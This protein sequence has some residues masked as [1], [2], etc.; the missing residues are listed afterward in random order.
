MLATAMLAAG[1][2]PGRSDPASGGGSGGATARSMEEHFSGKVQPQL[3][4]CRTCHIPGGVADVEDGHDFMLSASKSQDMANLRASWERLGKNNPTS[5]ILLMSSG[6]ETPHSGGAPW[7]VGSAQYRNMEILLKCFESPASCTA[8]LAGGIDAGELLPLLGSTHAKTLWE[9]YC[10]GKAD[11]VALPTDPRTMIRPGINEGKAVFFNAW[12]EDCHANLPEKEQAPKTCGAYRERRERG[13]EAFIDTLAVGS[14]KAEDYNDSWKKWGLSERPANFDEL[15]TLRYGYNNAPFRNPY[16]LPG[17][18]PNASNGGNGQLP[19]GKR[20]LKDEQGRWTGVIGE[21]ACFGCHG[22][23]IG[24]TGDGGSRIGMKNLG[25]GNNNADTVIQAA[26]GGSAYGVSLGVPLL[27]NPFA[28]GG[29]QRGQNNAVAGFELL[30][31]LL[32]YDSLGLNPNALKLAQNSADPHPTSEQQDTP[33][34]WNYGHRARKFFDAGQSIDSTRIVMAAG[35]GELTSVITADGKAYRERIEQFD[36]DLAAFF[37]S[38]ES[39]VY[40]GPIDTQLAEQGAILF[41]GKDLWAGDANAD[42]PRPLGGNGSCASCHGAYSPRYIHDP[43]YLENPVLGGMAAHLMPLDVIRT[44]PARAD[45]L[46]PYLREAY[47]T[48]FWGYPEGA[49][50]WTAPGVKNA[51][52]ELADDGLPLAARPQG[53]CGWER[54]IIGYQAPPL[55]GTWATAPYLHNGSVPT[56][57]QVLKS[58]DR[59]AIW[60]RQLQTVGEVAGFDQSLQRA[61]DYQRL[62]W[63]YETLACGDLPGNPL[64]NC[65]P[66]APEQPSITQTVMNLLYSGFNWSALVVLPDLAP[67]GQDK[68]FVYDTRKV[69]NGNGGHDFTDELTEQERKAVIEYLKTL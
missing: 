60:R 22:G 27:L 31:M 21:V 38:L 28:L 32:D 2:A 69:G 6:Q 51:V 63:K 5:R 61:Y 68:R 11:G 56:I 44:D 1:C 39:P 59:P 42:K 26:D 62:G 50:G 8:L 20:Q 15:Y 4:F 48:T 58:S 41:H 10:E 34:W 67:G 9:S 33:A 54:G 24:D 19:L 3:D 55:H 37:L 65:N 40:P 14:E 18:D 12:Y 7:P 36:Q 43:A 46:T 30:F 25:L 49:E 52:L 64:F 66:V 13:R 16:P 45:E 53:A 47:G 23:Q 17:E 57:E 29:D 35:V